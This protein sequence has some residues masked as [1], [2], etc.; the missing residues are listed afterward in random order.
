MSQFGRWWRTAERV[1]RTRY[2]AFVLGLALAPNEIPIFTY[3][4]VE[5]DE[6]AADL[7]FLRENGYRT[8]SLEEFLRVRTN[9]QRAPVRS[10]LLTFDDARTSFVTVALPLLRA[11]NARAVLFAPTYWMS[12]RPHAAGSDLFM[13]W[14]QVR[15]CIDSGV[16]DVESHAH[17]H[18]LVPISPQIVDFA[19]PSA[20]ARFDIYDWPMRHVDGND[21]LGKPPLGTP[22]YRATPLLSGSRRYLENEAITQGCRDLVARNGGPEFFKSKGWSSALKA[23][24][25]GMSKYKGQMMSDAKFRKLLESEFELSVA[26]F[27]THLGYPPKTLA[28]PWMLGSKLSLELAQHHGFAAAFGVAL[29]YGAERSANTALPV[30]GRLKCDWLRFLP[31]KH[32]SNVFAAVRRK[33][34]GFTSSQHLAH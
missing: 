2:P 20:L 25:R 13:S 3:H 29:D 7:E 4:D 6:F 31:G 26:E 30:F 21:E 15:E 8:L 32:R 10:V 9:R 1:S 22:V 16:V 5:R 11:F 18:A 12:P 14:L 33:L 17:R 19:S 24:C 28:Y 34:T 23:E 27:R